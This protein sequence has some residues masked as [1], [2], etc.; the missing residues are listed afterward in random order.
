MQQTLR[1]FIQVLSRAEGARI[2]RCLI[3]SAQNFH[4]LLGTPC[5]KHAHLAIVTSSSGNAGLKRI[6]FMF[7]H[8]A[9]CTLKSGKVAFLEST[10]VLFCA[11]EMLLQKAQFT[12]LTASN[13]VT[14]V[15]G[16]SSNWG[17][18]HIC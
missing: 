6:V 8:E 7:L 17:S 10:K 5:Q 4:A 16:L 18:C 1:G 11:A 2:S 14:K 15:D 3:R 12:K 9:Q 13:A